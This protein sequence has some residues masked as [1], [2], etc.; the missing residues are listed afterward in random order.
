MN[1][2]D[3][4]HAAGIARATVP[5]VGWGDAFVDLDNAGWLDLV[6]VNGH[7]YPQVDD[8]KTGTA[9]KEPKLVFQNNRDG[10]FREVTAE[11]VERY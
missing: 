8:A 7:V 9:Y 10:T 5:F 2:S 3:V 11:R 6:L 1:F 4:S